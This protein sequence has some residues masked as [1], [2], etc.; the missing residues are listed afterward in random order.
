VEDPES[1]INVG[2]LIYL[3]MFYF[4]SKVF[5]DAFSIKIIASDDRKIDEWMNWKEFGMA[6]SWHNRGIF[7]I[8]P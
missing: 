7:P 2:S 8:F 6:L 1:W 4:S 3:T 5:N